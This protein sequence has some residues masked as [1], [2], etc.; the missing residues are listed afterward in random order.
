MEQ[1][2]QALKPGAW[3]RMLGLT[4]LVVCIHLTSCAVAIDTLIP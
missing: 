3:R 1:P 2:S 4:M